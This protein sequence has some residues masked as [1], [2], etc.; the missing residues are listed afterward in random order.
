MQVNFEMPSY[1]GE[2]QWAILRINLVHSLNLAARCP[3]MLGTILMAIYS[4]KDSFDFK[5]LDYIKITLCLLNNN[6]CKHFMLHRI[7][8]HYNMEFVL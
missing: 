4:D 7:Q 5:A 3:T 2:A 8:I 1:S 6:I